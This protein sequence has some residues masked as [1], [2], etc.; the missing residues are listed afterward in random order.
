MV[1]TVYDHPRF[2]FCTIRY[3]NNTLYAVTEAAC[4]LVLS[5]SL[6]HQTIPPTAYIVLKGTSS[7]ETN[8]LSVTIADKP[9]K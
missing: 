1:T 7:V 4:V 9:L 8:F 6:S 5:V 3:L 2:N